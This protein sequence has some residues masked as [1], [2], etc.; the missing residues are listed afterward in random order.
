MASQMLRIARAGQTAVTA[1]VAFSPDGR[2]RRSAE[3]ICG[4][5]LARRVR[6]SEDERQRHPASEAGA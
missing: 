5:R 3:P 6:P 2:L 4:R 1:A